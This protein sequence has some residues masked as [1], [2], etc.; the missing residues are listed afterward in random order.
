MGTQY[1]PSQVKKPVI[2]DKK[3]KAAMSEKDLKKR[4]GFFGLD[5]TW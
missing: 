4:G 3:E 2:T 5:K 1:L